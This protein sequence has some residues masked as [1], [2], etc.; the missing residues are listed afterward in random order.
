VSVPLNNAE[1]RPSSRERIRRLRKHLI[2]SLREE[3]SL[4]KPERYAMPSDQ[5]PHGF[6]GEVARAA[7]TLCQGWCCRGGEEH[8]YIDGRTMARVRRARPELDARGVIRLYEA[9]IPAQG[10]SNG[11]IFQGAQGCTLD[12]SLRADLCNQFFCTGI[13]GY[14]KARI[15]PPRV[16]VIASD[17][18]GEARCTVVDGGPATDQTRSSPCIG[19]ALMAPGKT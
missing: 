6:A 2:E 8:A 3:R 16:A 10:Y 11:C 1:L 4:K 15:T 18:K 14:L 5:E 9:H 17:G 12:R 13:A 7:C 19:A